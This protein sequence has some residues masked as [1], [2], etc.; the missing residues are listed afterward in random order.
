MIWPSGSQPRTLVVQ[1][2]QKLTLLAVPPSVRARYTS[3]GPSRQ[4]VHAI[5]LPSP[6]ILGYSAG[7]RSAESRQARPPAAGASQTS[8]SATKE[9]RSPRSVGKR[10]YPDA[11]IGSS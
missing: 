11:V 3:G 6:E 7:A 9:R 2:D 10:R 4:L 1:S 5:R 8:S